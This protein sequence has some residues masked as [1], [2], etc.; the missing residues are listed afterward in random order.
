MAYDPIPDLAALIDGLH[1]LAA[2]G[3]DL[4]VLGALLAGPYARLRGGLLLDEPTWEDPPSTEDA[5]RKLLRTTDAICPVCGRYRSPHQ[6][7]IHDCPGPQVVY[8]GYRGNDC[9]QERK[10]S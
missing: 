3:G 2:R 9:K 6:G 7:V 4:T 1:E 10:Q 5:I 8:Q